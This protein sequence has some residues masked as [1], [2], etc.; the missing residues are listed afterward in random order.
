[1]MK[2]RYPSHL[3]REVTSPKLGEE[4]LQAGSVRYLGGEQE[5]R[6]RPGP[7]GKK[8]KNWADMKPARTKKGEIF[9]VLT[10]G[11]GRKIF[12]PYE[13]IC[14]ICW[15]SLGDSSRLS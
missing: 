11:R 15:S 9:F 6:G 5:G 8:M 12:R 2:G 14:S 3:A 4:H 7:Y 1:M 13:R 10:G